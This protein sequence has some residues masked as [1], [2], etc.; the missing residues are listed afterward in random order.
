MKTVYVETS[1]FSY[2]TSRPSRDL[3]AAAWQQ[4]T[5][6]W[7]ERERGKYELFISELVVA[8][9]EGGDPEAASRRL[10]AQKDLPRFDVDEEVHALAARLIQE[11]GVPTDAQADA[12]H[13]AIACV[14]EIDFLLTWNFRHIDNAVTKP[15]MRSIATVAGYPFPEI[16]TPLELLSEE[17]NNVP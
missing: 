6:Q 9:S 1:I 13:I 7:W 12:I 8:E 17:S 16:C 3:R 10:D 4:I 2:L 15:I 5:A 14:N 11:G